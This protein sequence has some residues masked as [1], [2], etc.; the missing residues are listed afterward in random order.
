MSTRTNI[1]RVCLA[2]GALL[3][4]LPILAGQAASA[5]APKPEPKR[6]LLLHAS[7]GANLLYATKIHAELDR[8]STGPLEIYDASFVTGRPDSD[9]ASARYGDYL[10]AIFPDGRIDL[11][12]VVGGASVRLY[13]RYRLQLFPN[14]PVLAIAEERRL[15]G[16]KPVANEATLAT[17]IDFRQVVENILR[18]LPDTDNVAVLIGNSPIE[19]YWVEQMQV[20]FAPFAG[21]VAFTWLNELSLEDVL[22]RAAALPPR[23]AI[24]FVMM[25]AD[26]ANVAYREDNVLS[27]LRALANAP[28]FSYYDAQFGS[29]IVGGPLISVQDKS[30]KAAS[31]ALRILGGESPGEIDISPIGFSNPK[32]DWREIQRWGI[33]V[34][35]LPPG[36]EVHFRP[37]TMWEQYRLQVLAVLAATLLQAALI[38]WLIYEHRRRHLAEVLAR[39]S[40]SELTQMNRI[41]SAGELSASIAHE[42]NQPLTGIA[43]RASA[44]LRWLAGDTPDI[45]KARAA[46]TQIVGASHRASEIITSVR[47]MFKKDV[48]ERGPVDLNAVVLTVL[49][50][51]R[52]ELRKQGI[53]LITDLAQGL[54]VVEGNKIQLQQVVLNLVMNAIESMQF[55]PR[56]VLRVRSELSLSDRVQLSIEDT[57][58][59]IDASSVGRIFTPLFS[60]KANGMGMG[61]AICHSIIESHNGR[62]GVTSGT[63]GGSCF[64]FEIPCL[65]PKPL[66]VAEA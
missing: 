45:E 32:Y 24:F 16:S 54:P 33:G 44:G 36:S 50:L 35:N 58:T 15:L 28:I 60:T 49:A 27:M 13:N 34:E 22:N 17:V 61:L 12:V 18:L 3:C 14:T 59:G 55:T 47:A 31:I 65:L 7:S 2:V 57:G 6:V 56:R 5:T 48:D 26:A 10:R 63:T 37:P 43:T 41:A 19:R 52:I 20:A 62:I 4:L 38:A 29:G 66:H 46:L 64:R 39:N 53:D 40:M 11:A 1:S 9:L 21:R 23:S 30:S 42:V 51:L 8:Q 25:L